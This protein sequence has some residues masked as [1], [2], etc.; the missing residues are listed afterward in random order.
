MENMTAGWFLLSNS[1]ARFIKAKFSAS[2]DTE[3][4]CARRSDELNRAIDDLLITD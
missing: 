3:K 1:N 2:K 4:P